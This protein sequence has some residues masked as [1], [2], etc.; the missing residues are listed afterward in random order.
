[1]NSKILTFK[2]WIDMS[3]KNVLIIDLTAIAICFILI[4][5]ILLH[6]KKRK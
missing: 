1:M 2:E 6:G 3:F 5:L 4:L